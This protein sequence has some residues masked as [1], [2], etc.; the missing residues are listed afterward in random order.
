L[1]GG[2]VAGKEVVL[3]TT[4]SKLVAKL[5]VKVKLKIRANP[6]C[7]WVKDNRISSS[8]SLDIEVSPTLYVKK[9]PILLD[10]IEKI[11]DLRPSKVVASASAEAAVVAM[12]STFRGEI[13]KKCKNHLKR[14]FF[15]ESSLKLKDIEQDLPEVLTM[16]CGVFFDNSAEL[17]CDESTLDA[18]ID[19]YN[20]KGLT[21][22]SFIYGVT[23]LV[24][25]F[26]PFLLTHL[27]PA[28]SFG[29]NDYLDEFTWVLRKF[30]VSSPATK[31]K[32]AKI[33]QSDA[34][35]DQDPDEPLSHFCERF[36][37]NEDYIKIR[38]FF[39]NHDDA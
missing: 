9:D 2:K 34:V 23:V 36:N 26:E 12:A 16:I 20:E 21:L 8:S 13:V 38:D 22:W 28:F 3:N 35:F 33:K 19:V 29:S 7:K 27:A 5:N 17:E 10:F 32:F 24:F 30:M 15:R 25:S 14:N 4:N 11:T 37:G 18:V 6:L 1:L 39:E 31:K